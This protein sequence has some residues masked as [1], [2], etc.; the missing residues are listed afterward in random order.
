M[1][2]HLSFSLKKIQLNI[3][4]NIQYVA[5]MEVITPE[6]KFAIDAFSKANIIEI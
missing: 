3:D 1:N 6:F 4:V 2:L 5:N